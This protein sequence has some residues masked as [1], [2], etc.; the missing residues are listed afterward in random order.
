ML[1]FNVTDITPQKIEQKLFVQKKENLVKW[2][3]Q[4]RLRTIK[5]GQAD[6]REYEQL[7]VD[8]LKY[9]FSENVEFFDE[10]KKSN[11]R[12]YRFDFCGKI[13]TINTSEFF[14]TVQK[15]FGTKYLIFE[16]KNYEKAI[17]QKEIYTTEKYLYEKALRKVAIIISRKGMD[18]NAQKASRGSLRELGKLIIGLSDEDVNKL[19]DMKDNDEDPS[20]YLQVLLDN[21]LIDL[22]K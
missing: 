21:M 11:N 5:P 19:I 17:S 15:F 20:D 2:D 12:L 8:I 10:Q 1:S 14:D 6:A 3:L 4:E 7:C 18:E 9:L 22:E 16:F 13:R